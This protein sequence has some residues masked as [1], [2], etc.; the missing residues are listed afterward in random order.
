MYN[1]PSQVPLPMSPYVQALL[2]PSMNPAAA[3]LMVMA[4]YLGGLVFW[5]NTFIVF[6]RSTFAYSFDR[7]LPS[8]F[9]KVS[10]RTRGPINAIIAAV[11][12]S[13]ILFVVVVLPQSASYAFLLSSVAITMFCFCFIIVAFCALLL[14]K[15]KPHLYELSP[16]KGSVLYGSSIAMIICWA[17]VLYLLLTNPAYGA[18]LPISYELLASCVIILIAIYGV[19]RLKRGPDL[20]LA[21]TEIPPE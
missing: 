14:P 15:V 7:I 18:N 17:F 16:V 6:S 4:A 8:W 9:A 21:F 10:D 1:A 13:I 12:L 2:A 19:A 11:I 5:P 3:V 20:K